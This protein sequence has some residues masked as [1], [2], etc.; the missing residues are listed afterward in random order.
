MIAPLNRRLGAS[1]LD[2]AFA[3][4]AIYLSTLPIDFA[5]Q[6]GFGGLYL[7]GCQSFL[8]AWAL[9][10]DAW[11]PGQ[12]LGKRVTGTVITPAATE[13][14]ATR[15]HCVGRQAIF[16]LVAAIIYL[17]AYFYFLP[18]VESLKQG[19][20]SS[21]LSVS[22][23]IR[24]L[25]FLPGAASRPLNAIV[26]AHLILLGFVLLELIITY[27]RPDRRRILDLL[28]RTQVSGDRKPQSS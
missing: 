23:P 8:I 7:A 1:L 27:R 18:A 19:F 17:P 11:W 9:L 25:G 20:F 10:K 2:N 28:A 14:P 13:N 16:T 3:L 6:H 12:S 5:N 15:I 26:V 21:V 24:L 22:A 4:A